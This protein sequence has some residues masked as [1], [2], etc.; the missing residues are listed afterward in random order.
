VRFVKIFTFKVWSTQQ[1]TVPIILMARCYVKI[2]WYYLHSRITVQAYWALCIILL[3]NNAHWALCI[4]L[5]FSNGAKFCLFQKEKKKK[6]E[7]E[8]SFFEPSSTIKRHL[9]L[10]G[11]ST[12]LHL[13]LIYIT[14]SRQQM[15]SYHLLLK[16][17]SAITCVHLGIESYNILRM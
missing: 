2:F 10:N 14:T 1:W 16:C 17:S 7:E 13:D 9:F 12:W 5:L 4:I 3:F 8:V 11:G 15:C 6:E